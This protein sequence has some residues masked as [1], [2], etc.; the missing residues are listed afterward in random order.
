MYSAYFWHKLYLYRLQIGLLV[1][2]FSIS[3]YGQLTQK[4]K[5]VDRSKI[6]NLPNYDEK[7][8]H[9]GFFVALN[10]NR[11]GVTYSDDYL[12]NTDVIYAKPQGQGGFA[13]GFLLNVRL[14]DQWALRFLPSV[15]FYSRFID[16]KYS[17]AYLKTLPAS[18]R[19]NGDLTE[20]MESTFIE[21][22]MLLKYRSQRRQ[23]HR[24]YF[25]G[26]F[27]PGINAAGKKED[28][29]LSLR[30][31]PFDLSVEYGVGFE[32]YFPLFKFSPELR[33]SHGMMNML[34]PL[35]NPIP[36]Y[37]VLQRLTTHTVT[38]YFLFE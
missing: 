22:Q 20:E 8:L 30:Y 19:K 24:M 36:Q 28:N 29:N 9:Y 5:G 6:V 31:N 10:H 12:T 16:Y 1:F 18:V 7:L 3:S 38:L 13:L 23:N 21:M 34:Q 26:G 11:F 17:D 25:I 37:Q 15:G 27:K 4:T 33:F 32:F 14:A 35:T 2:L